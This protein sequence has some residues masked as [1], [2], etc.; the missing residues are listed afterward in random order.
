MKT[1]FASVSQVG[2]ALLERMK[3]GIEKPLVWGIARLTGRNLSFSS[4]KM[5]TFVWLKF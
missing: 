2:E 4:F 1:I 3:G 5:E